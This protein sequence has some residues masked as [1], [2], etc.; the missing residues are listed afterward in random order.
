MIA[1]AAAARN[2]EDEY[3]DNA[4]LMSSAGL[5]LSIDTANTAEDKPLKR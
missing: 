3:D 5:S 1:R 4:T 2:V